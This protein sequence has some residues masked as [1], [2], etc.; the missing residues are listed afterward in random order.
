[1]PT[2][3]KLSQRGL[4]SP[5]VATAHITGGAQV[6][7]F[8]PIDSTRAEEEWMW[9]KDEAEK[10]ALERPEA[11]PAREAPPRRSSGGEPATIGPSITIRG[12][13]TGEE[14][15]VIK[16]RVEGSVD[17]KQNS[18]TVG[19]EGTVKGDISGRVVTVEGSVE[20]DIGA[21]EQVVLRGT[22]RVQGDLSAPRV[23]LEDGAHF[24][25]GV[26]MTE[27][28]AGRSRRPQAG[29][30]GGAIGAGPVGRS[31]ASS[32]GGAGGA[33]EGAD[34]AESTE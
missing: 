26:D 4:H 12:E 3:E 13:V 16:G 27:S 5:R 24:R 25:G 6:R 18:V 33:V 8:R 31:P 20:G 19:P 29:A 34:L 1:V 14:D 15:L 21:D 22:A 10:Q 9:K 32:E 11:P 7:A 23:M 30:A 28:G 2:P 17:L